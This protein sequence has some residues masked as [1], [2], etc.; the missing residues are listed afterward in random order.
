MSFRYPL[1]RYRMKGSPPARGHPRAQ[2]GSGRPPPDSDDEIFYIL[3]EAQRTRGGPRA[4][5]EEITLE[6]GRGIRG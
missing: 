5:F 1:F 4:L 6:T 2:Q 3:R